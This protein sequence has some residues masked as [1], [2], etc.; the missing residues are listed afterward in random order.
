MEDEETLRLEIEKTEK[1]W[2]VVLEEIKK[3]KASNDLTDRLVGL[4]SHLSERGDERI[5]G[6]SEAYF[7]ITRAI[8]TEEDVSRVPWRVLEYLEANHLDLYREVLTMAL[9]NSEE[10]Y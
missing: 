3:I 8:K 2:K 6:I 7:S 10:K 4:I 1:I 9:P 5:H